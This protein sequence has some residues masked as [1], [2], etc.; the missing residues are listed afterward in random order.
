LSSR[1]GRPFSFRKKLREEDVLEVTCGNPKYPGA[2]ARTTCT[3]LCSASLETAAQWNTWYGVPGN[4]SVPER[5]TPATVSQLP[6]P[7]LS[8]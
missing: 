5:K 7:K 8:H 2:A 6:E 4:E 3:V 1:R